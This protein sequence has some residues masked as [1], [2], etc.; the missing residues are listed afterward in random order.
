MSYL[1]LT[2]HRNRVNQ[3]IPNIKMLGIEEVIWD[4][5][6]Q[7]KILPFCNHSV[8]IIIQIVVSI[9]GETG[10]SSFAQHIST[11]TF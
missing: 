11:L 1:S 8:L 3:I 10:I 7:R 6:S 9:A 2:I 4:V 5:M